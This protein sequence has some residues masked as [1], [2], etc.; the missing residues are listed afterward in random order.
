MTDYI[1]KALEGDYKDF[2]QSLIKI[3]GNEINKK[4]FR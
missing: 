3:V 1:E 2:I 4:R